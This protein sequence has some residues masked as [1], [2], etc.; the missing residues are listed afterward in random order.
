MKPNSDNAKL[1]FKN[2]VKILFKVNP[3]TNKPWQCL[4]D[5]LRKEYQN[6]NQA[7]I[8]EIVNKLPIL[9]C[10]EEN[11]SRGFFTLYLN[12]ENYK[13]VG[14]DIIKE[15]GDLHVK[16]IFDTERK[17]SQLLSR[18]K[19]C[20]ANDN[21]P[22]QAR[23]PLYLKC[24]NSVDYSHQITNAIV[25]FDEIDT[26]TYDL[27]TGEIEASKEFSERKCTPTRVQDFE[28]QDGTSLLVQK[29]EIVFPGKVIAIDKDGENV[30]I[31]KAFKKAVLLNITN[32]LFS[33]SHVHL[34]WK[35]TCEIGAV[36]IISEIG[37]KG[38]TKPV[39]D[40]GYVLLGDENIQVDLRIGPNAIKAGL[41]LAQVGLHAYLNNTSY[42]IN[43]MS[44]EEIQTIQASMQRVPWRRKVGK[45]W[46]YKMVYVGLVPIQVTELASENCKIKEDHKMLNEIIKYLDFY[47]YNDL[48]E[49]LI[50]V[51]V[52]QETKNSVIESIKIILGRTEDLKVLDRDGLIHWMEGVKFEIRAF[53]QK[54]NKEGILSPD[55]TGFSVKYNDLTFRVPP[56]QYLMNLSDELVTG[57][58]RYTQ[59]IPR[60]NKLL[61][62]IRGRKTP[63]GYIQNDER[64]KSTYD[65]YIKAVEAELQGKN[66]LIR[67]SC[68]V[69]TF[70]ICGK[71]VADHRVPK[72]TVVILNEKF[73]K[74][75]IDNGLS[76]H[77]SSRNPII[78][79][80]QVM[81]Q[82][83]LTKDEFEL[84]LM[85]QGLELEDVCLPKYGQHLILR[86]P[87]DCMLDQSDSDGDIFSLLL[88]KGKIQDLLATYTR[89]PNEEKLL[90]NE[91]SWIENYIAGESDN[92]KLLNKPFTWNYI[93]YK[94]YRNILAD[95]SIAKDEM[96]I[97]THQLWE[98]YALC[99]YAES[100]EKIDRDCFKQFIYAYARIVQDYLIRAI[101]HV[102]GGSKFFTP[103]YLEN[104]PKKENIPLIAKTLLHFGLTKEQVKKFFEVINLRETKQEGVKVKDLISGIVGMANGYK[105]DLNLLL[106]KQTNV[107]FQSKMLNYLIKTLKDISCQQKVNSSVSQ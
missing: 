25:V 1:K 88:P 46:Q 3:L 36:R 66:K 22:F 94:D 7:A 52:N 67:E 95:S 11:P 75:M 51:E 73:N 2:R 100:I 77:V 14:Y 20:V 12:K 72:N 103:F 64:V 60:L 38:F 59:I 56:S 79:P 24:E 91:A 31:P 53:G 23:S 42:L 89:I 19:S 99:Q 57:E 68:M 107:F 61:L 9:A 33:P 16:T 69:K 18:H 104:I 102:E 49:Q 93:L 90:D 21:I 81:I 28:I 15:D 87:E 17:A 4:G 6:F 82:N 34:T 80:F 65:A 29:D 55:N 10:S 43:K 54:M 106:H 85:G 62:T 74:I 97:G 58:Y 13:S 70:G 96:G 76:Y 48:V 41:A 44:E 98:F 40:L 8:R 101:K 35:G 39:N 105:F 45:T 86:N 32:D 84:H 37:I 92:S 47:N 83:V 71:Q 30:Y 5:C 27:I 50:N 63:T 26:S 78:W